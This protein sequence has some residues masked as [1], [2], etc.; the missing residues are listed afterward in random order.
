MGKEFLKF[1]DVEAEKRKFHSSKNSIYAGDVI[2]TKIE[3]SD[4]FPCTKKAYKYFVGYQNN[5]VT[6]FCVLL[7]KMRGCIKNFDD[8]K[9]KCLL[10]KNG[11]LLVKC[12][13]IWVILKTL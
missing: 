11:N 10:I 5:E 3:I 1:G 7:P 4:E 12:K 6:P 9:T 8:A 2:I 13:E